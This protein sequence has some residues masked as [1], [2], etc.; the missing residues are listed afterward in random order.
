MDI[1][2]VNQQTCSQCGICATVCGRGLIDFEEDDYP[3]P[4]AV[5][6][7]E[8]I[9][10]G[11]CVAVCPTGS[12]THHQMP[13]DECL[14][15]RKS[16]EISAEQCDHM[17]KSRRSI[18]VYENRPVPRDVIT[19]IIEI[20][21]YAPTGH[22]SQDV[23]WLVI[24]NKDEL[25]RLRKVGM[26]CLR[27]VIDTQPELASGLNIERML[28]REESGENVFLRNALA[29]IVAHADKN[30]LIAVVD[31]TIALSY[32]DLAARSVGLGCCWNGYLYYM[33]NYYPPM[34]EAM[35]LPEGHTT[36]GCM[37]IGYPKFSYQRIPL[38]KPPKI[39]WR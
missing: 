1:I 38:R 5:A 9:L 34:Q 22:N 14:P 11:H 29:I 28:E 31:C 15:V 25:Q 23:E 33:A 12:L 13:V 7:T 26:D 24:D 35:N 21:R 32:F 16:L 37:M 2:Q 17:L 8:C 10:C 6:E 4:N 3:R 19:R 27:W 36:Y 20:A 30:S 18:R 39:N